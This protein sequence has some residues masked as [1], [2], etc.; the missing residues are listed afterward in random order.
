MMQP[1]MHTMYLSYGTSFLVNV[2]SEAAYRESDFRKPDIGL[3]CTT[4]AKKR[5]LSRLDSDAP[6]CAYA[7]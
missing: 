7:T 4:A 3:S 1:G 5:S 2:T 6:G